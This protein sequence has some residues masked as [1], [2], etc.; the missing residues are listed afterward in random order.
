MIIQ[1]STEWFNARLGRVTASRIADVMATTKTGY[2]AGRSN[3]MSQLIVERLTGKQQESYQ[4]AAMNWGLETEQQARAAYRFATDNLVEEVGFVDHPTILM[5]GASPD[6]IVNGDGLIEIKCPNTATHIDFVLGGSISKKY[7]LQMHW[8]MACTG[9]D[10]CDFVSFDPRLPY[11]L[12]LKIERIEKNSLLM[13]QITE[14]VVL[15]LDELNNK[16]K[17]LKEIRDK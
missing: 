4:S 9:K 2:G 3:Y 11:E 8:Q 6:G 10:W 12:Q 5:T 15:F 17:M 13:S 14:E 16:E 1:G 7:I